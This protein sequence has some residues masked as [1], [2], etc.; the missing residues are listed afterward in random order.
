ML[1]INKNDQE[2]KVTIEYRYD[3]SGLSGKYLGNGFVFLSLLFT[4]LVIRSEKYIGLL[5]AGIIWLMGLMILS[6]DKYYRQTYV[7]MT[8]TEE[9]LN[10]SIMKNNDVLKNFEL[11]LNEIEAMMLKRS[12]IFSPGKQNNTFRFYKGVYSFI[13]LSNGKQYTLFPDSNFNNHLQHTVDLKNLFEL[14]LNRPVKISDVDVDSEL[15]GS[16]ALQNN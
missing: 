2:R 12:F 8:I 9:K 11:N 13:A 14:A 6:V 3:T 10:Y 4:I 1:E 5:L 7:K 15:V 16:I